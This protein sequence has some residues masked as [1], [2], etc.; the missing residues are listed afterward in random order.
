MTTDETRADPSPVWFRFGRALLVVGASKT[1]PDPAA[2]DPAASDKTE[3]EPADTDHD[4]ESARADLH[5]SLAS[6]EAFAV[7]VANAEPI[8]VVLEGGV[9]L[10]GTADE[11]P[12]SFPDRP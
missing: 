7:L 6:D 12:I 2:S 3:T 8:F 5:T 4:I 11:F 1:L 10:S 9:F